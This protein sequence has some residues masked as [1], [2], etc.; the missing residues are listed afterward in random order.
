M[1]HK[2]ASNTNVRVEWI[3]KLGSHFFGGV[4]TILVALWFRIEL[5]WSQNQA[6][7]RAFCLKDCVRMDFMTTGG[8]LM[9]LGFVLP[10]MSFVADRIVKQNSDPFHRNRFHSSHSSFSLLIEFHTT[11]RV[12]FE[13]NSRKSNHSRFHSQSPP[14]F[15]NSLHTPSSHSSRHQNPHSPF[16]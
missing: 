16:M 6:I 4:D 8:E 14:L 10:V 1:W 7:Q 15:T 12:L 9:W 5:N 11:Q 3:M 2:N 13:I